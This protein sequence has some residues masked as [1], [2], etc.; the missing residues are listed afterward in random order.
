MESVEN[1]L[2]R[3]AF[4]LLPLALLVLRNV[5]PSCISRSSCGRNTRGRK[6]LEPQTHRLASEATQFL[7]T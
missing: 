2:K 3:G 6:E 1:S 5:L 4:G 7:P